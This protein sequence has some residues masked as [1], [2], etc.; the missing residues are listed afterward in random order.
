M[1]KKWKSHEVK[2]AIA[3]RHRD[4]MFFTEVKDGPTQVV[5]H[6]SKIDALAIKMSWT[7][8]TITGYEV[9]VSRS[10]FLR[11][12]KWRAY[13]PMCNQLYFAVAPGVCDVS[14]IP[15]V[16][17]LVAVTPKGGL[18]TVRKAPWREIDMPTSMFIYLMF[19]YIGPSRLMENRYARSG[20]LLRE[21]DLEVYRNY[22]ADKADMKEL[23]RKL[24]RKLSGDLR[25]LE[26][27][28]RQNEHAEDERRELAKEM[29]AICKALGLNYH[30]YRRIDN[31]LAAIQEMKTGGAITP[32]SL[33]SLRN[34]RSI[35]SSVLDGMQ[36][37]EPQKGASR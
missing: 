31:C 21:D 30:D 23:G 7:N 1:D 29:L 19:T 17:G 32:T 11:D 15:D 37:S 34:A 14:E 2:Q 20:R 33:A 27:R 10:D 13:L 35:L 28:A 4:D 22:L 26:S 24:G 8:F 18:R 36:L 25:E 3:K 12:E 5:H 6:H 16:C 9:K